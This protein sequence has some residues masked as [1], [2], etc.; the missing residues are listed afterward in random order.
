MPISPKAT[1]SQAPS[2]PSARPAARARVALGGGHRR[3]AQRVAGAGADA[4]GEEVGV[5]DRR[6]G[7]AGVDDAQGGADRAGEDVGGGVAGE[8]VQQHLPGDGLRVGGDAFVRQAV[9]AG[10]DGELA[11]AHPRVERALGAGDRGG[12]V[13]DAAEGAERLGLAVDPPAEGRLELGGRHDASR[14]FEPDVGGGEGGRGR[15]RRGGR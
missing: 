3:L 10:E 2:A 6:A 15:E 4:A 1:A 9:V 12:E 7:D 14:P 11:G 13:L 8:E 5:V